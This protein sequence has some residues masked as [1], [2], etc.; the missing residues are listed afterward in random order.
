M[1]VSGRRSSRRKTRLHGF[2]FVYN[3]SHMDSPSIEPGP[4]RT[5]T[6][7]SSMRCGM[8]SCFTVCLVSMIDNE[9]RRFGISL[10]VLMRH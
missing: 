1:T 3:I 10:G 9:R 2:Y 4:L 7:P 8:A 6:D 5:E